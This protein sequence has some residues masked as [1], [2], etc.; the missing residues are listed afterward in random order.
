V[1]WFVALFGRDSL[2]VSLQNALVYPDFARG[3]LDTLGARQA[4]KC[5]DFRDAEPG[6]I[7]HELRFG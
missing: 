7:L 6:K 1:P 3:A 4:T 2:I 5:D